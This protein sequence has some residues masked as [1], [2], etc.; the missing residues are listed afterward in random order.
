MSRRGWLLFLAMGLIW[1]IPYLLIKVAVTGGLTPAGLVLLRTGIG[2][3]ILLPLAAR[4]GGL[5]SLLP[6]WKTVLIYTVIE[7]TLPWGLLSD[8]E[9][10]LSS[11]LTGLLLG[12]V[13]LIGA[14][15]TL[16][17]GG[18]ADRLDLRRGIGLLVGFGGVAA[19]I[20]LDISGG[21]LVAAGEMALVSLGYAIGPIIISRRLAG[22]S[23]VSVVAISL[24]ITALLYLPI[25]VSQLP[26]HLPA[27]PVLLAVAVLGVI[28]TA[29]AFPVFFALIAEVG[30]TRA[31]MITYVNPAVAI[32]LGLVVLGEALTAGKVVGFALILG[33]LL[34]A[35]GRRQSARVGLPA[36]A[37][38]P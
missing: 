19:L 35:S 16:L 1:G 37:A 18:S 3:A 32:G 11:S 13:P 17:P 21:D 24:A 30:P 4:G 31:Q 14:A 7:V 26:A 2:A 38:A 34:L 9:R 25:G 22:V 27:T 23:V 36:E 28:C 10:R 5:R 8:A 29:I 15:I 33:G 20:G 12:A 6:H